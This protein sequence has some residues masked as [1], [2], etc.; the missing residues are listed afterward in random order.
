MKIDISER[1]YAKLQTVLNLRDEVLHE[2]K[3][4]DA[5]HQASEREAAALARYRDGTGSSEEWA[6]E[7]V[8]YIEQHEAYMRMPNQRGPFFNARNELIDDLATELVPDIP[9]IY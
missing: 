2:R 5:V 8:K 9:R 1:T 6:S 7:R 3:A 4:L